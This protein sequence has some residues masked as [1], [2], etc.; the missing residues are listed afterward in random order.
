M[1]NG[2]QRRWSST[3]DEIGKLLHANGAAVDGLEHDKARSQDADQQVGP[4][5]GSECQDDG[6]LAFTTSGD[7]NEAGAQH[8]M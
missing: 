7:C 6:T 3:D 8:G 5:D 2:Q 4:G 1:S